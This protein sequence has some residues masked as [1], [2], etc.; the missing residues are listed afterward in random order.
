M[1]ELIF[2]EINKILNLPP[3][4]LDGFF[5]KLKPL[6]LKKGDYFLTEGELCKK[7]ALVTNGEFYSYYP[8]DGNDIIEDFCLEG[9]FLAD[10]PA[11]INQARAQKNF[12]ALEDS[13]LLTLSKEEL[14]KLYQSNSAYERAGRLMAE[15]LFYRLGI[16]TKR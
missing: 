3:E 10:Y 9:C 8:K 16:K 1:N 5:N 6:N 13:Q 4:L 7:I 11:F 14:D 12:K 2:N 15:Y